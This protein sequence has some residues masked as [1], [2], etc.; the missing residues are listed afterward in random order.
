VFTGVARPGDL[1]SAPALPSFVGADLAA[2]FSGAVAV[3]PARPADASTVVELLRRAGLPVE[4]A[5]DRPDRTLVAEW[6]G[7]V[8]GTVSLDLATG[9]A[10][11]RSLAVGE[12]R[13]GRAVGTALVAHG[14]AAAR[15]AGATEVYV[16]T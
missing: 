8:A 6:N 15:R 3:R 5:D 4:Q 7:E 16:G 11:L 14:L 2:L 13:R 9:S 10:H 1:V 12:P